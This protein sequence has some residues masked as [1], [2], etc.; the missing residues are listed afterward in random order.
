MARQD[1]ILQRKQTT[2]S[3]L[4]TDTVKHATLI[5]GFFTCP[6]TAT[7]ECEVNDHT[8]ECNRGT[9]PYA[10]YDT[11][12]HVWLNSKLSILSACTMCSARS[13]TPR[14]TAHRIPS[15]TQDVQNISHLA[16]MPC[17]KS[18]R[19]ACIYNNVQRVQCTIRGR[20]RFGDW[21]GSHRRHGGGEASN[22]TWRC[23]APLVWAACRGACG[24]A[25]G[26]ARARQICCL[27]PVAAT[28]LCTFSLATYT[29]ACGLQPAQVALHVLAEERVRERHQQRQHQA[30]ARRRSLSDWRL[31]RARCVRLQIEFQEV[32]P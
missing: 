26:S 5:Q 3:K 1:R 6:E 32:L 12:W 31:D 21:R 9:K 24:G 16:S 17:A 28:W 27:H 4:H 19:A 15:I 30:H 23:G 22:R 18:G 2:G 10:F 14:T 8:V 20:L 7:R 25:P 13:S 29:E 11:A